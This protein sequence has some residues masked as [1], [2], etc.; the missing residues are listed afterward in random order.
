METDVDHSDFLPLVNK[1]ILPTLGPKVANQFIRAIEKPSDE[2]NDRFLWRHLSHICVS[3]TVKEVGRTHRLAHA[4]RDEGVANWANY[5][6]ELTYWINTMVMAT[7]HVDAQGK[8]QWDKPSHRVV[9]GFPYVFTVEFD[10]PDL[11]FLKVQ[12]S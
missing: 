5:R 7:P 8:E 6:R 10:I 9:G 12:M 4:M 3:D 1:Y 2:F 11:E